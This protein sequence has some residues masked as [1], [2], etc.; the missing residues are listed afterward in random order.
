MP[1][2]VSL[3][4]D[5]RVSASSFE[6]IDE[7]MEDGMIAGTSHIATNFMN[8]SSFQVLNSKYVSCRH[9]RRHRRLSSDSI[10]KNSRPRWHRP[11]TRRHIRSLLS[12]WLQA[13][14]LPGTYKHSN[15]VPF[16]QPGRTAHL[17][18]PEHY[19]ANCN[20]HDSRTCRLGTARYR[21]PKRPRHWQLA[22][23]IRCLIRLTH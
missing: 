12:V 18:H 13:T 20:C 19:F 1:L 16:D 9:H 8:E 4:S 5:V 11:R 3:G 15:G 6:L 17:L 2:T 23:I 21:R 10:S 14:S 7:S 22:V